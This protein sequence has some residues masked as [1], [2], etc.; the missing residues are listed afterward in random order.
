MTARLC[1]PM[2]GPSISTSQGGT[3]R[4]YDPDMRDFPQPSSAHWR[5]LQ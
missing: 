4:G 1:L 3:M 2:Y 5:G